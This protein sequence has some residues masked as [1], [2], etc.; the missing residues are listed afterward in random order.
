MA[1]KKETFEKALAD[2]ESAVEQLER[3]DLSLEESLAL[4][5]KGVSS[6]ALCRKHLQSAETRVETL[7]K[8]AQGDLDALPEEA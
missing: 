1:K 3:E 2:L 8:N 4:F 7:L 6:A 5:E